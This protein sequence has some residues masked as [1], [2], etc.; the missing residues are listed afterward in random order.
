MLPPLG[1]KPIK[2]ALLVP[3]APT[4]VVETITNSTKKRPTSSS[5]YFGNGIVSMPLILNF[6]KR[7]LLFL[8]M[9]CIV[10]N[11]SSVY[12]LPISQGLDD[13][14]LQC[15][16]L[17]EPELREELNN[18]IQ[19]LLIDETKVDFSSIVNREWNTLKTE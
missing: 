12:A 11:A 17:K 1:V 14:L 13:I 8:L 18:V 7:A 15:A 10:L 19:E 16:E 4:P 5:S 9:A 6:L 2:T 3:E